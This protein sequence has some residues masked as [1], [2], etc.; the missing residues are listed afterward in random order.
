MMPTGESKSTRRKICF[1]FT[2]STTSPTSIG[3]EE[4]PDDRGE[5]PLT[6]RLS[7]GHGRTGLFICST[8]SN[9]FMQIKITLRPH[10]Y[11][12]TLK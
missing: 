8:K 9:A 11:L 6:N 10:P 2:F 7:H 3:L 4:N 12:H 1:C 5:R